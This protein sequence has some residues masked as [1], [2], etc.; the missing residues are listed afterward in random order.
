MDT[1]AL[2]ASFFTLS[3]AGFGQPPRNSFIDRCE[4]AAEAGFAGISLHADDL[5]RTLDGGLDIS[6]LAAILRVN[7]L[8]VVEIEFLGGWALDVDATVLD[9]TMTNIEAVADAC[10][11]RHV[12]R[13]RIPARP[14]GRRCRRLPPLCSGRAACH[15]RT[16][17]GRRTVSLVRDL[18]RRMRG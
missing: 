8:D 3:G 11:G 12:R 6:E 1:P 2:V 13:G 18:D 15:A 5:A 14:A 16:D 17:P 7:G 10:G 9:H 4:A